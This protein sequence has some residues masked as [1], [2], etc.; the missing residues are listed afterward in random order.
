MKRIKVLVPLALLLIVIGSHL[1]PIIADSGAIGRL[2]ALGMSDGLAKQVDAE[3]GTAMKQSHLPGTDAT[4]NLGSSSKQWA[5]GYFSGLVTAKGG[6][7]F[8]ASVIETVAAGTSAQGDGALTAGKFIHLVTGFDETKVATLPACASAN[9]GEVHFILNNTTNKFAK[10][11]PASGG[12]I[13]SLSAN[14]AYTQ[15][16]AGQGGKVLLCACQAA[17]Q[18][19]CA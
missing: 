2:M 5:A 3:Y 15:G 12:T 11:F 1:A 10:I 18:W 14:A 8:S 17:N 13:N 7:Q 19:Y 9:I 4:Y 16:V 6:V